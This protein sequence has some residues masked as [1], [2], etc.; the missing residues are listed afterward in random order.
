M[1]LYVWNDT[2]LKNDNAV[3]GVKR[4]RVWKK[5]GFKNGDKILAIDGVAVERFSDISK[6]MVLRDKSFIV[7]VERP[8]SFERIV[9]GNNFIKDWKNNG[10]EVLFPQEI[11]YRLKVLTIASRLRKRDY[12][13]EIYWSLLT[14]LKLSF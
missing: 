9:I 4:K 13:L 1:I 12:S 11:L 2:Y 8:E 10:K 6:N 5:L 14:E 3:Y 7:D